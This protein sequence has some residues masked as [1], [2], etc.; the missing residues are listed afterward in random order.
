M[1]NEV[2]WVHIFDMQNIMCIIHELCVACCRSKPIDGFFFLLFY[3]LKFVFLSFDLKL[4]CLPWC[5][6]V[7]IKIII[8]IYIIKLVMSPSI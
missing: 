2:K 3:F 5:D 4:C 7:R 6:H 8:V 1:R